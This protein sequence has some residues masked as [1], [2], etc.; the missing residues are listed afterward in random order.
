VQIKPVKRHP[1]PSVSNANKV[2]TPNWEKPVL[3]QW[4]VSFLNKWKCY[5]IV[6]LVKSRNPDPL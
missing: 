4:F 6:R 1:G 2:R 5:K 3:V